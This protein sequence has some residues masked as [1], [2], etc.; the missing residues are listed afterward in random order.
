MRPEPKL[1]PIAEELRALNATFEGAGASAILDHVQARF[2]R[3]VPLVSSF[4]AESVVLLHLI[5]SR[6][7]DWPV[8]FLDTEMLF[9]ATRAYQGEV[10]ERLGLRNLHVISPDR[11]ETFREDPGADLN[12]RDPDACCALRKTRPLNAA[13]RGYAGWM[14]GRKRFQSGSRAALE[15]FEIDGAGRIKVNP[16]ADWDR[17]RIADYMDAHDLPRHPLVAEGFRSIGCA[18]CTRAVRPGEDE[19]AG[20][21]AGRDKEECGIH[22]VDGRVQRGPRS[23]D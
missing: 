7:R 5:A 2:G 19:R 1:K 3:S 15:L 18:P 16:L 10:A 13:L 21:W 22:I 6:D 14:T 23:D 11:E 17:G 12:R 4:G 9:P 8:L 20:R